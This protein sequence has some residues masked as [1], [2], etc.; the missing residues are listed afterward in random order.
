MGAPRTAA[1]MPG[2]AL[3][4]LGE[5][6]VQFRL[7]RL[8]LREAAG[9]LG[10][11]GLRVYGDEL[12]PGAMRRVQRGPD[13]RSPGAVDRPGGEPGALVCVISRLYLALLA[14]RPDTILSHR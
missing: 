2:H 9:E 1:F 14:C 7:P 11:P 6:G 3:V 8:E 12:E 13:G 10:Q 5:V 4:A